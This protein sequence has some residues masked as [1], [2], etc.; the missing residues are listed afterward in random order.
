[1]CVCGEMGGSARARARTCVCVCC[2]YLCALLI[3]ESR[4]QKFRRMTEDLTMGN[5][6]GRPGNCT[7]SPKVTVMLPL[8]ASDLIKLAYWICLR[9]GRMVR[10]DGA[11]RGADCKTWGQRGRRKEDS[12]NG[13]RMVS[14]YICGKESRV[15]WS[16]MEALRGPRLRQV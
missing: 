12:G 9:A 15:D 14:K 3:W 4:T 10:S 7:L 2:V 16:F 1:M 13:K 6:E 8:W 5:P 11:Q